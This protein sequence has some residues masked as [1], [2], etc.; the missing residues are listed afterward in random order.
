[1]GVFN[2][3][4]MNT[5]NNSAIEYPDGNFE[6]LLLKHAAE[7]NVPIQGEIE[8][9]SK[10]NFECVHCYADQEKISMEF[11]VFKNIA[12]QLRDNGCVWLLIT[13]GEPLTHKEFD[14]IWNYAHSIGL[15]LSLFTNGSRITEKVISVLEKAP[16]ENIE[17]SIYSLDKEKQKSITGTSIDVESLISK[18]HRLSSF[19]QVILKTPLLAQ[20]IGEIEKIERLAKEHRFGFRMDAIIHPSIN[21]DSTTTSHRVPA[22]TA[23]SIV[24]KDTDMRNQLRESNIHNR[25]PFE[26]DGYLF[27]CSAGKYSF[28]I[29]NEA[30]LSMCSIYRNQAA[31]LK[32]E[33]FS[34]AWEKLIKLRDRKA[35]ANSRCANCGIKNICPTC[36]AIPKLHNKGPEFIDE[37][38]CQYTHEIA[39]MSKIKA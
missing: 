20:N 4:I 32:D 23:A 38:V 2:G 1:M 21:G 5:E 11:D 24:M 10:C 37:Y 16:P 34:E 26:T 6:N 18:L 35:V 28:H 13:G 8:I 17:V 36:P 30:R 3:W 15:R 39:A 12:D 25:L 29:D 9:T 33:T 7:R 19:S 22:H 14:K 27:P 31:C